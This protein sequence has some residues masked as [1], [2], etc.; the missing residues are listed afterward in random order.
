MKMKR[1]LIALAVGSAASVAMVAPA[2]AGDV[3]VYGRAQVELTSVSFQTENPA[4]SGAAKQDQEVSKGCDGL[5]LSDQAL[6]RVGFKASEDLGNGWK[7]LAKFEYKADT[8]DGSASTA[9][10]GN[11]DNVGVGLTPRETMVGLKGSAVQIE[12]GRLKSAYKYAGGV[13]YDAFVTT[14]MEA[15]GNGGMSGSALGHN[16]FLSRQ[17]A[18]QGGSGPIKAR[19][20]YGAADG[21]GVMS[22][23]VMYNQNNIEA[24]LAMVDSGDSLDDGGA[25]GASYSATKLGGAF[26][27][28]PHKIML[29][30][31][32][33]DEDD[34]DDPTILFL[35]YNMKM[36]KNTFV[37]QLGQ[38]DSDQS[39]SPNDDMDY[40]ALGVI[41]KFT[42]TTRIF[43]GYRSTDADAEDREDVFTV[44]L[45]KDF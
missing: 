10:N 29:Q 41:H 36:G 44:G 19:F 1:N 24:F 33:V 25:T 35:G 38:Y 3:T 21:D 26:K 16:G 30:Y 2:V 42:K 37:V 14:T 31:E 23:S 18:V 20:T 34:A 6:G 7:G 17:L 13:K 32:M 27:T 11:G 40:L 22:L 28:G 8:A 12:A 43:G 45:R 39:G 4:C 9:V 5:E 15:R